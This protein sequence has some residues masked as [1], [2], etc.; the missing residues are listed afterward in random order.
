[1]LFQLVVVG[2][3]M[4]ATS[5]MPVNHK[6]SPINNDM[7]ATIRK[8]TTAWETHTAETNPLSNMTREEL[9]AMVGTYVPAPRFDLDE[10]YSPLTSSPASW[11]PRVSGSK[12]EKCIHPVRD[13]AQCGS[14]WAFGSTEALSDRFCIAGKDVVL[15]PQDLV[16]CDYNNYGC[17]G[18][19][20][21]LAWQYLANTG[22]VTEACL[23]YASA[24]GNSPSCPT[25][26]KCADGSAWT[27]YKCTAGSI[28]NPT[29]VSSIQD[30][31]YNNGPLEGAF[32]VYEDFFNYKSGVYHHVS[33]GVAGGHAIKV[34]GYGTESGLN[35]W[36]CA[37]SWGPSWG[38]QGFFKIKQGDSGINQQMYGCT[39]SVA[40][41]AEPEFY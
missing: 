35:Y 24:S 32:T 22:A 27:K 14:C 3:A 40:K 20:L 33:G 18:G 1:M 26:K 19:Y 30:E 10:D 16:A 4:I 15:S 2:F 28:V 31:L 11:D 38:M 7:V 12:F 6:A 25:S 5:A 34:I 17:D 9:L 29:S 36:L 13:Q 21:N 39:P 8:T 23:P 37:N 41:S